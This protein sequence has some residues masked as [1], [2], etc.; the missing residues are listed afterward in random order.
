MQIDLTPSL[1]GPLALNTLAIPVRAANEPRAI[2]AG[3]PE[4]IM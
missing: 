3:R 1:T 4:E 2:G